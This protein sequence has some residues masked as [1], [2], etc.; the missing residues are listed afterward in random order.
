VSATD[1]LTFGNSKVTGAVPLVQDG[2]VFT[3][4]GLPDDFVLEGSISDVMFNYG[5][6]FN[7]VPAPGACA[8]GV[9]GLGLVGWCR[10]R[11]S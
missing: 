6:G 4:S 10:R 3:L 1:D 8:L 11:F 2:V 5:T 7:P 9:L